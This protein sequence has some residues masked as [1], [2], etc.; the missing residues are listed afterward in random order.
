MIR[1]TE[2]RWL[3][4]FAFLTALATL[5]LVGLG[6]VVTSKGVG[7]A[8]P[9]WPNTF[10]ENIFLF[11][12]SKW[13]GGV[14]YEH[15][16][17]LVAS[18]VGLLT[19]ILAVWLWLKESRQCLR[20]LGV[21][22]FVAVVLQGVLGGLRVVFDKHGWG[23]ELG[24]FHATVAQLFLVLICAI[25]L[26][27]TRSWQNFALNRLVSTGQSQLRYFLLVG[28]LLIFGQ[29]VLGATM[30]HQ[31]AGL[32]IP[33]FPLAYGKIWPAMDA[34]SVAVYN[35]NRIEVQAY[36]PITAFQIGLQMVHRVVAV[37]ILFAVIFVLRQ[38]ARQLGWK[39]P[40]TR[41]SCAWLGLIATQI[42]LGAA[43]IWSGKKVDVTTLHVAVGA[44]SLVN[45]ALLTT[46]AFRCF[47]TAR[48][49]IVSPVPRCASPADFT[50]TPSGVAQLR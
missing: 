23:T 4:R 19:T 42:A 25:A 46:I 33:D 38:T 20:W 49:Q 30:R 27:T 11:P 3:S 34:D 50:A 5:F 15:S 16:H 18:G 9:D 40:L 36:N 6:G 17:R 1:S 43:T 28:T 29:L 8:V 22:A 24:I 41:L 32:A 10:G 37:A 2:N 21:A 47:R 14:F 12:F 45:G 26:F 31:H 48:D 39:N 7:M 13:V 44:M 35:Q